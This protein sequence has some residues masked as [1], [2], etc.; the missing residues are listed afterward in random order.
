M[1]LKKKKKNTLCTNRKPIDASS[2]FHQ[3]CDLKCVIRHMQIYANFKELFLNLSKYDLSIWTHRCNF[4]YNEHQFPLV[5][6]Y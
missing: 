5:S 2:P 3:I 6:P 1:N 4:K